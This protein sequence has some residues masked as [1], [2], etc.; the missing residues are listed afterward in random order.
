MTRNY[1]VLF[2]RGVLGR[3]SAGLQG[4]KDLSPRRK[5]SLVL[6]YAGF[7]SKPAYKLLLLTSVS[8]QIHTLVSRISRT[9]NL[10]ERREHYII[11]IWSFSLAEGLEIT[12]S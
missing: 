7:N 12:N 3:C 6:R 8:Q 9:K 5:L 10:S 11:L 4:F 2:E 1:I